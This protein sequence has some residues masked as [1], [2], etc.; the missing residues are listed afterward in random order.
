MKEIS[1]NPQ[2]LNKKSL[3]KELNVV[4]KNYTYRELRKLWPAHRKKLIEKEIRESGLLNSDQLMSFLKE[5]GA[6]IDE[7]TRNIVRFAKNNGI[8]MK[9][10]GRV[11]SFGYDPNY[12]YKPSSEK[13]KEIIE[14]LRNNNNSFPG[15]KALKEKKREIIKVFNQADKKE[16]TKTSIA[17]KV[18]ENT[19]VVT[20]RKLVR[21][22]LDKEKSKSEVNEKL[23]KGFFQKN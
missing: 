18:A 22:V 8:K 7:N 20:N 6:A 9:T 19:G 3:E 14:N 16:E 5:K 21:S 4:G 13:V 17:E 23:K 12:F 2:T 10:F 15:R 11:G 1:G